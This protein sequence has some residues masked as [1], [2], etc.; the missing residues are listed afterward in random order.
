MKKIWMAFVLA[1]LMMTAVEAR[2]QV[3]FGVKAGLNVSAMSF[4]NKVFD[5]ANK[6]GFFIGPMVK[7]TVPVVG[8]S[9][10][11]AALFNQ[12]RAKVGGSEDT[13]TKTM[14][15]QK[16]IDIP[17]N[18]RYGVGL[19]KVANI[20]L[21]AGPQWGINVGDKDFKWNDKSSYSLKNSALSVNVGLG[22]T[23]LDHLQ[24]TAN[25]N[26]AC[27]KTASATMEVDGKTVEAES[28]N[29]CLKIAV[30]YWF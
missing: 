8:L 17:V 2:A 16:T 12:A 29:H 9:L 6:D 30:G 28:R 1:V 13:S 18:V 14:I 15:T 5:A 22:T 26:I 4:D 25:Y 24:V 3:K 7:F 10:D 27:T 11:A 21:F 20:F 19:G 23:V